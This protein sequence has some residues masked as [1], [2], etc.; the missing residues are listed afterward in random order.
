MPRGLL[1]NPGSRGKLAWRLSVSA[2]SGT[3]MATREETHDKFYGYE[4]KAFPTQHAE[5]KQASGFA[6]DV[7]SWFLGTLPEFTISKEVKLTICPWCFGE[8][9]PRSTQIDHV[10]PKAV[11]LRYRLFRERE[12]LIALMEEHDKSH[13]DRVSRLRAFLEG[14]LQDQKNLVACCT[15]CNNRKR[16]TLLPLWKIANADET[17]GKDSEDFRGKM[18]WVSSIL[19]DLHTPRAT[20]YEKQVISYMRFGP[21][22]SSGMKTRNSESG[23]SEYFEQ[24]EYILSGWLAV[25]SAFPNTLPLVADE[26]LNGQSAVWSDGYTGKLCFYCLGVYQDHAFQIDHIVAQKKEM[27]VLTNN[28]DKNLIP[29]CRRCNA[30]K[31]DGRLTLAFL[32][33][34]IGERLRQ[35]GP[36]I[37]SSTFFD[38]DGFYRD[39]GTLDV[40][41][42]LEAGILQQVAVLGGVLGT[43]RHGW[44]AIMEEWRREFAVELTVPAMQDGAPPGGPTQMEEEFQ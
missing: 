27:T 16:N 9:G 44:N 25:G 19:L 40:L 24:A 37:E 21:G 42:I 5:L 30:T 14:C 1:K 12:S 33:N 20:E 36:G 2:F 23:L 3:E 28:K 26:V 17:L 38:V 6:P 39:D 32:L 11:Y 41:R 18:K 7:R 31:S 10:V 22:F 8:A 34:R 15:P 43:N 35:R 4:L 13:S 29:V